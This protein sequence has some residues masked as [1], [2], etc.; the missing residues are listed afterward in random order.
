MIIIISSGNRFQNSRREGREK[1]ENGQL[2]E[3][4]LFQKPQKTGKTSGT[5]YYWTRNLRYFISVP[6]NCISS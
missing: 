5:N 6:I 3:Y 4:N 2:E 1:N